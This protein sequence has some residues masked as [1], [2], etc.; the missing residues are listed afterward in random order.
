MFMRAFPGAYH[1]D[2]LALPP[3]R[4]PGR[5]GLCF[6]DAHP[7]NFGF[8]DVGG[9]TRFVYNDLDDSGPCPV[10]LD[11]ARYFAVLRLYFDDADL[12]DH[13][14]EQYVDTL[15]D[16][17]RAKRVKR[18]LH[19]D[20][21]R[22]GK[23]DLDRATRDGRFVLDGDLHAPSAADRAAI[24]KLVGSDARLRGTTVLDVATLDRDGGGSGGLARHWILARR[25]AAETILELKEIATPGTEL[26]HHARSL[27]A[28]T[29]L[30]T[31]KRAFWGTAAPDD[32]FEVKLGAT[33]FLLRDRLAK[34]SL[35]L[36]DLDRKDRI[37]VLEAQAS[38]L[39]ALHAPALED[40]KKDT[41]RAWLRETCRTL[42]RRW[43][44]AM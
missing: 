21:Q 33:R 19:P 3:G 5:E 30:E 37:D 24:T 12:S 10:L 28:E 6:G 34:Q 9:E 20:M 32:W 15:K 13:V 4:I 17:S 31:L 38:L 39:A 35:D 2:A 23:K 29:R 1:A 36:G 14:L 22:E 25:G 7:D 27:P 26:G 18:D 16:P 8:L 11:A 42:A 44:R 41:V 43:S 40:V